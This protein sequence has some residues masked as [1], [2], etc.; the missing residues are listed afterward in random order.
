MVLGTIGILAGGA[1]IGSYGVK[2][3]GSQDAKK[4]YTH[5]TAAVLRMKDKVV[6]DATL[7]AENCSDIAADAKE[8]NEKRAAAWE[9]KK[10]ED[11]KAVLAAATQIEEKADPEPEKKTA[12]RRSAAK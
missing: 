7:I 5:I 4:A 10:I 11:A 3:L 9:A 1:L 6:A 2:I 12:K 8:L